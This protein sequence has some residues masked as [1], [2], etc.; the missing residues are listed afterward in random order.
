MVK[1]SF[2]FLYGGMSMKHA[3]Y[4]FFFRPDLLTRSGGKKK[5]IHDFLWIQ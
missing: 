5:N 4:R 2:L 1:K 3:G